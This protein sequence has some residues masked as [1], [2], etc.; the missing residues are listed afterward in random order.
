MMLKAAAILGQSAKWPKPFCKGGCDDDDDDDDDGSDN[1][2]DEGDD[3]VVV[4]RVDD[5]DVKGSCYFGAKCQGHLAFS[6]GR[7]N[8]VAADDDYDID[9]HNDDNDNSDVDDRVKS[10]RLMTMMLKAAAI[11]GKV[12]RALGAFGV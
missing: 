2:D 8:D 4:D 9:N 11:F 5:N 10:T 3:S 1:D 12:P 6:K 7:Y